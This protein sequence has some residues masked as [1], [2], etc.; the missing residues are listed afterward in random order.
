MKIE[1]T[2]S[3]VLASTLLAHYCVCLER[4]HMG[5]CPTMYSLPKAIVFGRGAIRLDLRLSDL[6]PSREGCIGKHHFGASSFGG[7]I[8]LGEGGRSIFPLCELVVSRI[9]NPLCLG[10]C[11]PT[12]ESQRTKQN[13]LFNQP[14]PRRCDMQIVKIDGVWYAYSW[15]TGYVRIKPPANGKKDSA[16]RANRG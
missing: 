12:D 10:M 4:M 1:N 3:N 7:N 6:Q 2:H 13:D 16:A 14:Q 9:Q 15:V 11:V 8:S 5:R